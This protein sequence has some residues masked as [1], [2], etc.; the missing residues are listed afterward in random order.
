MFIICFFV[1]FCIC[2]TFS[3]AQSFILS[4]NSGIFPVGHSGL[5][6]VPGI[7]PQSAMCKENSLLAILLLQLSVLE[8]VIGRIV[9]RY[10]TYQSFWKCISSLLPNC[11]HLYLWYNQIIFCLGDM[12]MMWNK[13]Y[14]KIYSKILLRY[15]D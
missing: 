12:N 13:W 15:N 2:S 3:G 9:Y 6:R 4:L 8:L 1:C 10:F 5:H 7:K 14:N 11:L